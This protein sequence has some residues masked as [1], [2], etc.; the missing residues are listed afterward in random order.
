MNENPAIFSKTA[1]RTAWGA[2]LLLHL[3]I[4]F[5]V[6]ERFTESGAGGSGL[7]LLIVTISLFAFEI[8]ACPLYRI[9]SGKRRLI[10]LI[11]VI[12]VLH[13][14]AIDGSVAFDW[15]ELVSSLVLTLVALIAVI[16]GRGEVI[17]DPQSAVSQ[18]LDRIH[19]RRRIVPTRSISF[20][21]AVPAN[22]PPVG[23]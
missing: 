14:G 17:K 19:R 8:A 6:F 21:T 13:A 5:R 3:P 12:A 4:A 7:L 11:L 20:L 2:V 23:G 9:C 16:M 1:W 18:T 22:A 10:A 15:A